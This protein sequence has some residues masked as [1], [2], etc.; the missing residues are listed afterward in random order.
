MAL[1]SS[2]L[3]PDDPD[4]ERRI[5]DL[6]D[7][8]QVPQA[9]DATHADREEVLLASDDYGDHQDQHDESSDDG[10]ERIKDL[11]PE[12]R[13]KVEELIDRLLDEARE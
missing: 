3:S 1:P 2:Y 7:P 9:P 12:D 10:L 11:S 6:I 8:E 13:D 5:F 4:E